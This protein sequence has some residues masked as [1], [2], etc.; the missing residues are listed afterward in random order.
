MSSDS[1]AIS[2]R[3]IEL[4]RGTA[5]WR[6]S[7]ELLSSMR[8]AISVLV[9][10]AIAS[11]IGTVVQQNQPM[12]NYVNQFGP[13]WFELFKRLGLYTVYSAAWFFVLL[14]FLVLSTSLCIFR[15]T[16]KFLREVRDMRDQ[17]R[18]TSWRA[19][20][21]RAECYT[22]QPRAVL[23]HALEQRLRQRGFKT[24]VTM[25][26]GTTLIAAKAGSANRL[27]Y[28]AAHGAIVVM[29]L[30]YLLDTDLPLRLQM[31]WYD[32]HPVMNGSAL[33]TE[34]PPASRFASNNLSFRAN[35][36]IPEGQET[37]VAIIN[38]RDGAFIQDLPF[39]LKL[40]KFHVE[41]YPTGMPRSFVSDVV[42]TDKVSGAIVQRQIEVNKPLIHRG[43]AIY[44]SS[45]DDGGSRLQLTG[46]PMRGAR[47]YDFAFAG[48]VGQS[49]QLSRDGDSQTYNVE[50]TG[51]RVINVENLPGQALE[52]ATEKRLQEHVANVVAS[53][54]KP[55]RTAHLRNVGPSVQYKIRDAAGQAREYHNYMLPFE[56][57]GRLVFL[58][59]MRDNP[60]DA[61]KYLR[62]PADA[63]GTM[64]EFMRLRAALQNPALRQAAARRFAQQSMSAG[65]QAELQT[66][67]QASAERSLAVFAE[68]GF[69]A[70][71]QFVERSVP[72]TE[73]AKAAEI[74]I[75]I[76]QGSLW[77]LWQ[78]ARAQDK[79]EPML[80][81]DEN[82]AWLQ[83]SMNALSD[84]FL[85]GAPVILSLKTFEH[86][87]ASVFQMTRAPGTTTVYIG[88][89]LLVIGIFAM[90]YVRERRMWW[91]MKDSDD[92]TRIM[93]AMSST[94]RTMDFEREFSQWRDE[95]QTWQRVD[96]GVK[97]G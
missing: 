18:E 54:T 16:P 83:A 76:L 12:I 55:T 91:W 35:A 92:G 85:Y 96:A 42:L 86:V 66:P 48:Q 20:G 19:F 10:I 28:I 29:A 36:L 82:G 68:G 72:E 46:Y 49:A 51:L 62:I 64:R 61:F 52:Q 40:N 58:S 15:N 2:T 60:N 84:S 24:R 45:F 17:V 38:Y 53:T 6:H 1:E 39:T 14:A 81:N 73:R 67:L 26:D 59:G 31:L 95:L 3:G 57:D 30:G 70:V 11:V 75:R 65:T 34:V 94:R 90:F 5:F 74:L 22:G 50:F 78:A 97:E 69:Q 13:F 44:Q 93:M 88:C 80:S 89:L 87:Q 71:A 77:E 25:Q 56:L 43:I 4:Q 41:Y 8:F 7:V 9:I 27:G 32:K 21:H 79:L 47:F 23:T 63:Q 37:D 33:I